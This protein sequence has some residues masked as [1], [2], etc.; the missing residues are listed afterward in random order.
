MER[1]L[2]CQST[3]SSVVEKTVTSWSQKKSGRLFNPPQVIENNGEPWRA[4]TSDPLIKS[5]VTSTPAGHAS[6]D[7]LISVTGCSRQRVYP[8]IPINNSLSVFWSQV[9][10]KF[11]GHIR[12]TNN[13]RHECSK[14]LRFTGPRLSQRLI[15]ALSRGMAGVLLL[16]T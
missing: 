6:Y 8:S 9:G 16:R 12:R 3:D 5:A 13:L 2:S 14:Q 7:L 11:S 1:S 15:A 10:H 4:R